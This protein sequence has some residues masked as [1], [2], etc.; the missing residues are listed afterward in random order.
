[1]SIDKLAYTVEE[2]AEAIGVSDRHLR[3]FVVRG[4]ITTFQ[5]GRSR[6]ISRDAL[7]EFIRGQE[8]Q[9]VQV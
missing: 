2:A 7:A 6:R 3:K 1:M 5:M 9:G 8:Q 4:E